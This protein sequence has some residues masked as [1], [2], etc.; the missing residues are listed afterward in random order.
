MDGAGRNAQHCR[1]LIVRHSGEE[2][3]LH[4]LA[5]PAIHLLQSR[6]RLF[7][8]Q[9]VLGLRVGNIQDPIQADLRNAAAA[10]T[11][12]ALPGA[13]D[14]DLAHDMRSDPKE[15]DTVAP[16]GGGLIYQ[17]QIGFVDQVGALEA[18]RGSFPAHMTRGDL[19]QLVIGQLQQARLGLR[20]AIVEGA[21]KTGNLATALALHEFLEPGSPTGEVKYKHTSVSC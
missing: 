14:Q 4:Y 11:G 1:D 5:L 9:Q 20:L 6:Q 3:H 19:P 2:S 17:P 16:G 21:E 7:E 15:M 18:A 10:L 8:H 12:M 13:I